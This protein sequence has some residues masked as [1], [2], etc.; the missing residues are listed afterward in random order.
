MKNKD[1]EAILN[2]NTLLMNI[3][4]NFDGAIMDSELDGEDE[5]PLSIYESEVPYFDDFIFKNENDL[6]NEPH[7]QTFVKSYK[8]KVYVRDEGSE[9]GES[10]G[11]YYTDPI[12]IEVHQ[13]LSDYIQNLIDHNESLLEKK[14]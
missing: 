14:K 6:V 1:D 11:S 2:E 3:K 13:F 10:E 4:T 7:F 9:D 5:I 12:S 8:S